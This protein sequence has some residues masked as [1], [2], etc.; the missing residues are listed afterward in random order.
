MAH[1]SA[2]KLDVKRALGEVERRLSAAAKGVQPAKA[3]ERRR[4]MRP[5]LPLLGLTV[6]QQRYGINAWD[7]SDELSKT[8]SYLL[9]AEGG[10]M[11]A[12]RDLQRV[13]REDPRLCAPTRR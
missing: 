2:R 13:S 9:E 5:A 7:M 8:Y 4:D 10:E 12:A 6:P 11:G 3:A 1:R